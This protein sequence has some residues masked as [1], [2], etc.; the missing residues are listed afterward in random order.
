MMEGDIIDLDCSW[1]PVNTF[2]DV[3]FMM[4]LYGEKAFCC[5]GEYFAEIVKMATGQNCRQDLV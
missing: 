1:C 4:V 2:A 5:P 3:S